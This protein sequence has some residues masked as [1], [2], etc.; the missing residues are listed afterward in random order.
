MFNRATTFVIGAGCSREYG[1]PLGDGLKERIATKLQNL[2]HPHTRRPRD[3]F[4]ISFDDD[5]D[6]EFSKAVMKVAGD[7]W[8]VWFTIG[9]EMADGLRHASSIDRYLDIHRNDPIK[10]KLGKMAIARCL[11]HAEKSSSLP[12]EPHE[13]LDLGEIARVADGPHWLHQLLLRMQEGVRLENFHEVLNNLTFICF[14]YD[15]VIEHYLY[16]AIQSLGGLSNDQTTN[17]MRNLRIF[18][19]Y[20][21][22][23]R[24]EWQP[25]IHGG[26]PGIYFGANIDDSNTIASLGEDLR[27][28]T[29]TIQENDEIRG[30]RAA[31]FESETIVFMGFSFLEQ[32]LALIRPHGRSRAEKVYATSFGLSGPDVQAAK[33]AINTML[34][35]THAD[36]LDPFDITMTNHTAG[37]FVADYGN[38]LRS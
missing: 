7:E 24:L 34:Q 26:G 15:R 23:G 32:N 4:V 6:T 25:D 20:G 29:E 33:V 10:V 36:F 18:H 1:L 35:G 16:H 5:E 38:L 2:R 27:I 19:P 9:A 30:I 14:N 28:F 12:S 22:L 8:P 13:A 17:I 37:G 21:S 11:I 3:E 31:M